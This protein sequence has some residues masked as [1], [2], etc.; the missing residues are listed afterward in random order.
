MREAA[1]SHLTVESRTV[2]HTE[3]ESRTVVARDGEVGKWG[4]LSIGDEVSSLWDES[5]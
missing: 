1:R 5:V 4:T 2:E 3:V